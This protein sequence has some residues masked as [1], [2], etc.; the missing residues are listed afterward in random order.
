MQ[1]RSKVAANV[2]R[3]TGGGQAW[4]G[5]H[6]RRPGL[7]TKHDR[8]SNARRSKAP[9]TQHA[10]LP[11]GHHSTRGGRESSQNLGRD[12]RGCASP[13]Q[14]R[15]WDSSA[16]LRWFTSVAYPLLSPNTVNTS[17]QGPTTR[18][19]LSREHARVRSVANE[20]YCA[21]VTKIMTDHLKSYFWRR[22]GLNLLSLLPLAPAREHPAW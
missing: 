14:L 20:N 19:I 22:S 10:N 21:E 13:A 17:K 4:C 2:K 7:C 11:N 6:R 15:P 12:F 3:A 16:T 8:C 5:S 1:Q 18:E 9:P